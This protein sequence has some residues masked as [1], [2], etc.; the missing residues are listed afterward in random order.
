[1]VSKHI[2]YLL[3]QGQQLGG[4]SRY[5]IIY[6]NLWTFRLDK[7]KLD[8]KLTNSESTQESLNLKK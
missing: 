8:Q 7:S 5:S 3:L 6:T 4:Q 2:R 1:M